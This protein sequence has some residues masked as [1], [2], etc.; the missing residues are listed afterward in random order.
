MDRITH[1]KHPNPMYNI[2]QYIS[3]QYIHKQGEIMG[4]FLPLTHIKRTKLA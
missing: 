4:V 2:C 1:K 3:K